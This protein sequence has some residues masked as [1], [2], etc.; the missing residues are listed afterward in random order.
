MR[1]ID[2]LKI[3]ALIMI[4]MVGATWLVLNIKAEV[5]YL[6]MKSYNRKVELALIEDEISKEQYDE[7][8]DYLYVYSFKSDKEFIEELNSYRSM[9]SNIKELNKT[10]KN[11]IKTLSSINTSQ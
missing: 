5:E 4:V 7:L 1:V 6:E 2:V 8:I 9:Y 11:E 10:T 3:L